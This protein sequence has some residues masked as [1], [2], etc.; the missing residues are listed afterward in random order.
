MKIGEDTA[1]IEQR[2]LDIVVVHQVV[3]QLLPQL[4][5]RQFRHLPAQLL[6]LAGAKVF[7]PGPLFPEADAVVPVGHHLVA[8][9]APPS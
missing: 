2:F 7:K 9:P 8:G 4:M 1:D 5:V 6:E 3:A